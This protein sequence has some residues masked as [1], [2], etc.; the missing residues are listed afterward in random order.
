MMKARICIISLLLILFY[1]CANTPTT[2]EPAEERGAIQVNSSPSGAQIWLNGT[3]MGKVTNAVLNDV[4]AGTHTLKLIKEGYQDHQQ[5]VTVKEGMTIQVN[6]VLSSY[7]IT[8]TSPNSGTLWVARKQET[9]KW[10]TTSSLAAFQFAGAAGETINHQGI[11]NIKLDL[12]EDG[13]LKTAIVSSTPNSGEYQ[14]QIPK[15][16]GGGR[17]YRI[18]ASVPGQPV[19]GD[20]DN[21]AICY[22]VEGTYKGT[23][24]VTQ[25]SV[26]QSVPVT[27]VQTQNGKNVSGAWTADLYSGSVKGTIDRNKIAVTV[28]YNSTPPSEFAGMMDIEENG[29][30]L[31]L[32]FSGY[33]SAG[34]L[35]AEFVVTCT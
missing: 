11:S 5:T 14:W 21:F 10:T 15:E 12:F 31:K 20:S 30:K 35:T 24:S 4:P 27:Y 16:A 33:T 22:N 34:F 2:P 29:D 1:S 9:I 32:T 23:I 18:R 28:T 26:S 25:G 19:F 17:E 7:K 3:N 6:V 8:V 13:N